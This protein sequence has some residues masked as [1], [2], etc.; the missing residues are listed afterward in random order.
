MP[1]VSEEHLE[2]R[3]QQILDAATRCFARKG[4]YNTSMQDVFAE[5][6]LSAGAVYRYFKSKDDLIAALASTASA[7]IRAVMAE[8]IR[9]DP[10]PT[11]AELIATLAQW[12]KSQHGPESR[13]RLAPQAWTLALV[14]P[15]AGAFVGNAIRGIRDM[16][17]EYAQQM[18]AAGWLPDDADLDAIASALFGLL[19]GVLLQ[20]LI[21]DDL[22]PEAIAV[23]VATLFRSGALTPHG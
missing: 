2:R 11:P 23:G 4:F 15:T 22:D 7:D 3:R 5:A 17:R 20:H 16:W 21:L 19:P 1:R 13:L 14:D 9:R 10:L 12:I 18:Q 6:D 8:A